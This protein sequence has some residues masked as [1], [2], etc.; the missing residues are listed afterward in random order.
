MLILCFLVVDG[1]V[2]VV[3]LLYEKYFNFFSF[4]HFFSFADYMK[5]FSVSSQPYYDRFNKCY[6]NILTINGIPEGPLRNFVTSVHLTKLSEYHVDTP[7][8]P[9]PTCCYALSNVCLGLG[10]IMS[11]CKENLMTPNEIPNLISYLL[12]NGYQIET[13]ISNFLNASSVKMN[14]YSK[15]VLSATY[16]GN[17]QPNITYMR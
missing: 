7:C 17:N 6:K 12:S 4:F 8:N 9:I 15:F 1:C 14:N 2:C 16:Y 11:S 10:S 13:Q 3:C 5:T